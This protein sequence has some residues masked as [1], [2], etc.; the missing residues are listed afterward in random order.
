[1]CE[2][3]LEIGGLVVPVALPFGANEC[4]KE[5]FERAAGRNADPSTAVGMTR[6]ER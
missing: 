6:G 3:P 1:M 4:Y 2:I 5:G